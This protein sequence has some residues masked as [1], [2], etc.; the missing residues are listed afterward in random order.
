MESGRKTPD[1]SSGEQARWTQ[2]GFG[3][4][5]AGTMLNRGNQELRRCFQ[6]AGKLHDPSGAMGAGPTV[7]H[8]GRAAMV[9]AVGSLGDSIAIHV[10]ALIGIVSGHVMGMAS[11]GLPHML[12]VRTGTHR[13][14]ALQARCVRLQRARECHHE[15]HQ[16]QQPLSS[17]NGHED[18][19]G[20]AIQRR[21][22]TKDWE[23]FSAPVDPP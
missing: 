23:I 5:V 3:R 1:F 22:C 14:I 13:H 7:A 11:R 20:S 10:A 12:T 16:A 2:V 4:Y 19:M 18:I 15:H 9:M 6:G 17:G 8:T 21:K